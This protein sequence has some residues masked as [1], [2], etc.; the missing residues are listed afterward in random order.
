M[1]NASNLFVTD[2]P[3]NT[4]RR[5]T[6]AGT[7]W[8]V[9]TIAGGS[10][11]DA[12]GTGTNA[13]FKS[14]EGIAVDSAGSLY[15]ADYFNNAIRGIMHVGTNWVVSTI[16]GNP[17]FPYG[18]YADGTGTN[19]SFKFPVGI[20][21]VGPGNL[22]VADTYNNTIRNVTTD[23]VVRTL[24]GLGNSAGCID[25]VGLAARFNS[26]RGEAVDN[27][28]N[29]YVADGANNAIR[30]VT[31]VGLVSSI[32]GNASISDA[33][34]DP[35]GGYADGVGSYARFRFPSA[36]AV[37]GVG[38]LYVADSGNQSIRMITPA[39]LVSTLAGNPLIIDQ[40]GYPVGGYARRHKQLRAFQSSFRHCCG[41][42]GQRLCS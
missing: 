31:P 39:G 5:I 12:D 16:A 33:S 25:G 38:N 36:V 42:I 34:G 35:L 4:I 21:V 2:L 17:Q 28:G 22:C 15:V 23:G 14:P 9:S 40:W 41:C 13:L 26:P 27:A 24:A 29:I 18:G 11:G 37:D 3:N 19:A 8:V 10:Y 1:D 32:A 30:K 7:N 20:A 6:P